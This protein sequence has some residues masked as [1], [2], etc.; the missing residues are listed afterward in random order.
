MITRSLYGLA[1]LGLII[2]ILFSSVNAIAASNTVPPTNLGDWRNTITYNSLKPAAC[3]SLNLTNIVVGSRL[4]KGKK[5]VNNLIIGSAGNDNIDGGDGD[6]CIL[7]GGGD[8]TINGGT[9]YNICIGGPGKK[10]YKNCDVII[11]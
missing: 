11:P 1:L 7:A 9:G 10:D 3:A 5:G 6:N 2:L 8:D 4:I